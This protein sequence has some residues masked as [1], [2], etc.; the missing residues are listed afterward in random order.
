MVM[1]FADLKKLV[2]AAV[3][4]HYDHALVLHETRSRS[5]VLRP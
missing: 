5:R 4:E 3:I 1:D 2:N